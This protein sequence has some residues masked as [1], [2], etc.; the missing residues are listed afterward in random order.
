MKIIELV[1][2]LNYCIHFL[3]THSQRSKTRL[4][5]RGDSTESV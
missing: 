4:L 5:E 3:V 1:K 2:I